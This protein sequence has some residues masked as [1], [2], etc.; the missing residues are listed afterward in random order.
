MPP[1][2]D[3]TGLRFGRLVVLSD[4]GTVAG[5][6]TWLCRCDCGGEKVVSSN[7]L[8]QG[9][10]RSCRCL[11]DEV[12]RVNGR[13]TPGPIAHGGTLSHPREYHTWKGMR[14]RCMNERNRDFALYGG[15]GIKVAKRWDS[16]EAFLADM[17]PRPPGMSIDR[18]NNDKGYSPSN[19]KWSTD[20]QQANNR[21]P[22]RKRIA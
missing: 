6:S 13:K 1:R 15:R 12:R 22:R 2:L 3:L 10:V 17:G 11:W 9:R 4:A 14:Q 16:F 18:I 7:S 5:R 19:C 20:H 8:N 21:R